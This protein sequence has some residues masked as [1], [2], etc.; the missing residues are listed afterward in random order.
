MKEL[1]ISTHTFRHV[2][3]KNAIYVDKTELIYKLIKEGKYYFL[4]RPRRFGKSLLLSTIKSYFSGQK[5][6]FAGLKIAEREKDWKFHPVIHIDYSKISYRAGIEEFYQSIG[7]SLQAIAD[8]Y[9]VKLTTLVVPDIL[10]EL[11]RLLYKK[12]Q[13]RVVVLIDEYDKPLVDTLTD[14]AKF[15]EN[16]YVLGKLYGTLKG[17]DEYLRFVMLTGVSRFSSVSVF[18]GLNNI[19][20]ISLDRKYSTLVGFTQQELEDNFSDYLQ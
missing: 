16:R 3:Q 13:S 17:L 2:I 9:E 15:Q 5:E 11:V 18:S 19:N 10:N 14:D 12:Y 8:E 20:D 7:H 1:P 6:L 4:A